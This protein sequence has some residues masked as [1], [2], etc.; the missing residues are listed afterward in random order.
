MAYHR[1]CPLNYNDAHRLKHDP[2]V[3]LVEDRP[4]YVGF[5]SFNNITPRQ[6]KT[7]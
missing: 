6:E 5:T 3:S 1:C 2:L 4:D 7:E